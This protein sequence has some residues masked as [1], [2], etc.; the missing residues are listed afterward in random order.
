MSDMMTRSLHS[1]FEVKQLDARLFG[2]GEFGHCEEVTSFLLV[3]DKKSILIDSGMGWYPLRPL[4]EE[5]T[6]IPCQ[7]INTHSHF[8][9]VGGN[10]EFD[11]VAMYD[12]P[13]CKR[14]A[15]QGFSHEFLSRWATREHFT[16]PVPTRASSY[17]IPPFHNVHF[18]STGAVFHADPFT[19]EVLHTPGHSDDSVCLFDSGQG[20]LFSGDLLYDGPIYIEKDGGLDKFRRS[21]ETVATLPQIKRIFSS[22]N[23]FE[24]PLHKLDQLRQTLRT[25][26]GSSLE[27][28]VVVEGR[29]R[30]VQY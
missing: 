24:F 19:L 3:G 1:W 9:H 10:A 21:V 16:K 8:D 25:L 20:W 22:H 2:I 11:S 15:E 26:K 29:L 13:D 5:I 27:Q 7:V 23:Y 14:V 30:L 28:E 17:T 12:H 6:Q 4:I 18:F